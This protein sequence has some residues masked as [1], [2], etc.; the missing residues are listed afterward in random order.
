MN[1]FNLTFSLKLAFLYTLAK[2]KLIHAFLPEGLRDNLPTGWNN[3]MFWTAFSS[4]G[5]KIFF[6]YY[7][8]FKEPKDYRPRESVLPEFQLSEED[9]KFF[10]ENGYIGPFDLMSPDQAENLRHDLLNSVS[11][12]ESFL[13]KNSKVEEEKN[14]TESL[15]PVVTN[16]RH[17]ITEDYKKT[18]LNRYNTFIDRHLDNSKIRDLFKQPEITERC[19]QL[20]GPDLILWRSAFFNVSPH[21]KGTHFHQNSTWLYQDLKESV[22]NPLR[23]DELFQITCWVAL[24]EANEKNGCMTLIPGTHKEMVPLKL[25][26]KSIYEAK[27]YRLYGNSFFADL[28]Y[29]IES[30][31]KSFIE[32]KAGQLFL[33]CERVLHGSADNSTDNSRWGI[34]GRF[35]RTDTRIFTKEI[36]AKGHQEVLYNIKN[37]NLDDFKVVLVRGEDHFGYNKILKD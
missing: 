37:I 33:F 28:D 18:A 20:L 7:C 5:R 13:A 29:P 25:G 9:I 16:T 31:K 1:K 15:L 8:E 30:A 24:T 32:M 14:L 27:K 4:G 11:N 3:K 26:E 35:V 6:D 19:A 10:Y 12:T 23:T 34:S 2:L 17:T 22:V 21:S 36:L